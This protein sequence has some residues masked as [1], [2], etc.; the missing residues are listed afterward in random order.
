[1]CVLTDCWVMGYGRSQRGVRASDKRQRQDK[2][3]KLRVWEFPFLF[4]PEVMTLF[5]KCNNYCSITVQALLA[6]KHERTSVFLIV[7][8]VVILWS[9]FFIGVIVLLVVLQ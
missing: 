6:R 9:G 2:K 1:M 3:S 8:L 7:I 4:A 5:G